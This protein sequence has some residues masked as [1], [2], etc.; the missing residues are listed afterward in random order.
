MVL[1]IAVAPEEVAKQMEKDK[2]FIN[3]CVLL[4]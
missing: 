4:K 1:S 3:S 2:L